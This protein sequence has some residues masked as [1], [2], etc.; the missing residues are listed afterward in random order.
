[1]TDKKNKIKYMSIKEFREKGYLQELN[2]QFLHPLGLALA[3]TVSEDYETTTSDEGYSID[4]IYDFRDEG[5]R[6]DLKN[7]DSERLERYKKN[8]EYI[9]EQFK[10]QEQLR[11]EV[12]IGRVEKIEEETTNCWSLEDEK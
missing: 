7:A 8:A 4:G 6:F 1:M 3:I 2:R 11:K 5:I 9:E 10:E 12:G